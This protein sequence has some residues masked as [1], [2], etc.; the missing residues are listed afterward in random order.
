MRKN[1]FTLVEVMAVI[2][3]LAILLTLA[4]GIYSRVYE[5]QQQKTYENKVSMVELA[6]E[7]WASETNLS[8]PITITVQKLIDDTYYQADRFDEESNEYVVEDPRDN[9]SLLCNTIDITVDNGTPKAT[10]NE[11]KDCNLKNQETDAR[12]IHVYPY[13]YN[14][15]TKQV[16]KALTMDSANTIE[17]TKTAVLL[18][19]NP[20]GKYKD[21]T[22][23]KVIFSSGANTEE[24]EVHNNILNNINENSTVTN[25]E[26]YANVYV[27]DASLFLK[28]EYTVNLE[29]KEGIKSK[30]VYIQIDKEAPTIEATVEGSYT[31]E[32]KNIRL[33]GSD[34][35]GSGLKGF[36]VSQNPTIPGTNLVKSEYEALVTKPNG[37]Y[38]V[39]AEDNVGNITEEGKRVEVSNIDSSQPTCQIQVANGTLGSNNWYTS[40][41]ILKMT[42][43]AATGTGLSYAFTTSNTPTYNEG[44]LREGTSVNKDITIS[45]N[46]T[47]TYYGYVKNSLGATGICSIAIKVDKT[48]PVC[49]WSGE[50]TSWIASSRTVSLQCRD[51]ENESGC[52]KKDIW[53][54]TFSSNTKEINIS[55][56]IKDNAGNETVCNKKINVYVD[57]C[58]QITE[59]K[60]EWSA[61]GPDCKSTR[62]ITTVST[63]GGG[64]VCKKTKTES[65]DCTGGSCNSGTGSGEEVGSDC[66]YG[67]DG[68]MNCWG[69]CGFDNNGPD[70]CVVCR[71]CGE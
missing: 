49:V 17:W 27:V 3:V 7:K 15:E 48:P 30:D 68:T 33:L 31:R 58:T 65:K 34:G 55:Y 6:A 24:K 46:G 42:S 35:A 11:T 63:F 28:K 25:V 32:E 56:T 62:T 14:P 19:V 43:S 61:C 52:V 54:N 36:Y 59:K 12:Y 71:P 45:A 47:H 51:G 38:Y 60:G 20:D 44:V 18:L 1:G 70:C 2:V 5:N 39:F 9:S 50:S 69:G 29:T 13:Q 37:T 53:S 57:K 26:N 64:A 66:C 40:N 23:N 10:M 21:L 22:Y 4:V 67:A 8:R 41:V 16:L